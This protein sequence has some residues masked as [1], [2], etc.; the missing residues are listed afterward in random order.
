MNDRLLS[1]KKLQLANTKAVPETDTDTNTICSLKRFQIEI[2]KKKPK[3]VYKKFLKGTKNVLEN[4]QT[5]QT[6]KSQLQKNPKSQQ[7]NTNNKT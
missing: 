1:K 5:V 7:Q 3:N 2:L 6:P 4:V